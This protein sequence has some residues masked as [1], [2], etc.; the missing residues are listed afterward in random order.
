MRS[1]R[2][3][4]PVLYLS[5]SLL[6]FVPALVMHKVPLPL[7]NAYVFADPYWA[8][9]RPGQ[10]SGAFN[11]TL[12]DITNFFYPYMDAALPRL[13]HGA[14][15]LWNPDI[16]SG[17]PFMAAHQPAVLYPLNILFAPLGSHWIW[18]ATAIARLFLMG[19]GLHLLMRRFGVSDQA[20]FWSGITYQFSA[21]SI[22]W[23]HFNIHNVL[24]LLPLALYSVDR[25]LDEPRGRWFLLLVVSLAVQFLGGHPETSVLFV[26]I[27]G[28]F[29]LLQVIRQRSPLSVLGLLGLAGL[30]AVGLVMPQLL[31][32]L[33]LLVE[34]TTQFKRQELGV[35]GAL[36]HGP[37]QWSHLRHWLLL[38][39]PYLHGT[40]L[41]NQ[42]WY[43]AWNYNEMAS[44]LGL[45][46]V[47][48]IVAGIAGGARRSLRLYWT[49]VAVLSLVVLYGAPGYELIRGLP[50]LNHGYGIRMSL[51]WSI[52]G[53]VLAGFGVQWALQQR[54]RRRWIVTAAAFVVVLLL[55][56]SVVDIARAS[57]GS[58]L[59]GGTPG[60]ILL[61]K[62]ASV[63]NR[64][65]VQLMALLAA[66]GLGVC[67]F[68]AFAYLRRSAFVVALLALTYAEL[69]IH[70]VPYNG[71][72]A[73]QAIYPETAI[74]TTLKRESEP[75]RIFTLDGILHGNLSMTQGLQNTLGLDDLVSFRYQLF[76]GRSSKIG[77]EGDTYT[78]Q[79][80]AQRFLDM[81]NARF[82]LATHAVRGAADDDWRLT[83]QDGAVRVYENH[84]VLPR[85]YAVS[86]V[87]VVAADDAIAA[88]YDPAFDPETEAIVE[89]PITG[90]SDSGGPEAP[91]A[92][93]TITTYEPEH[94]VLDVDASEPVFVV[95]SES[96][97]PGWHAAIDGVE[98]RLYRANAVFRGVV[99]PAGQHR[100]TMTYWPASVRWGLLVSGLTAAMLGGGLWVARRSERA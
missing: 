87:R 75:F 96:Y 94:V 51:S 46:S 44:Y 71:F 13:A 90:L 81:A 6:F 8:H 93:V 63:Y 49:A 26:L 23:L 27:F 16:Y 45:F 5:A 9:Y 76:A 83:M 38:A 42:Y 7:E 99:V 67:L 10:L 58:V 78:I 18:I 20:A 73:P 22:V 24:A 25:L 12:Y 11:F 4:I 60:P 35:T 85:A 43:G 80:L 19:W 68:V 55:G 36:V 70:G 1:S 21:S 15:P 30:A 34:S 82:V 29:T 41:N 17:M 69:L 50:I 92:R 100:V 61:N 3:W 56:W 32:T 53:A 65:N 52:S 88:V 40:P 91:P 84:S 37:G 98:T 64:Q 28:S 59:L 79:P 57:H 72:S 54:D 95:L 97:A 89:E 66:A 62:I 47:P 2:L 74:T 39:N 77:R 48:F 14:I 86:A 33:E 31:A